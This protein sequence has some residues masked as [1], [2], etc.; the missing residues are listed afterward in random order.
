MLVSLEHA[1]AGARRLTSA[2]LLA[3]VLAGCSGGD[4]LLPTDDRSPVQLRAVSGHGQSAV[5]GSPVPYPLV[6]EALDRAGLPVQGAVVTFEF[7]NP[8]PGAAIAPA[9]PATDPD[10]RASAAVTLGTPAGD[11]PVV[12]YL[13]DADSLRVRFLLTAIP[14]DDGG[15]GGGGGGGDDDDEDGNGGSGGGGDEGEGDNGGDGGGGGAG[16]EDGGDEDDGDDDGD[17]EEDE[18][19]DNEEGK[20]KGKGK[21]KGN[22]D[23]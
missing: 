1:R 23:D 21:G 17:D 11:Q 9:T 15:A 16:D 10:G 5:A 7:V 20:G 8:P 12:A 13:V 2:T 19:D 14:P 6:V 22:G 18:D 3:L 4:L